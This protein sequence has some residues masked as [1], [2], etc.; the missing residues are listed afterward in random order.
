MTTT[1]F[2]ISGG[3]DCPDILVTVE[4]VDGDLRFTLSMANTGPTSKIG[5][6]LG[7]FV[8]LADGKESLI[9][10][11]GIKDGSGSSFDNAGGYTTAEDLTLSIVSGTPP[12]YD[13]LDSLDDP[14]ANVGGAGIDDLDF[15]IQFGVGGIGAGKGDYQQVTF[16]LTGLSLSDLQGADFAIRLQSVGTVD[17]DR[18]DSCKLTGDFPKLGSITGEKYLDS[19]GALAGG[20][21][22]AQSGWTINLYYDANK[23]GNFEND[24][25]VFKTVNTDASGVY[26][27]ADLMAGSYK[28]E[29]VMQGGWYNVAPLSFTFQITN[30][31]ENLGSS[32]TKGDIYDFVNTEFGSLKVTKY[33]DANGNGVIDGGETTKLA[34]WTFAVDINGDGDTDDVGERLETDASGSVTFTGLKIG[35]NYTVTEVMTDAQKAAWYQTVGIGGITT[36]VAVSGGQA[37]A[38]FANTEYGKIT[39]E[40]YRDSNGKLDGGELTKVAG[41]KVFLY[42]NGTD[43]NGDGFTD[44]K[45]GEATTN[46]DGVYSFDKLV[47][48]SYKIVEEVK[49]GWYNVGAKEFTFSVTTS[50]QVIGNNST[51]DSYDFINAQ[52]CFEGRTPGFWKQAQNYDVKAM[53][54]SSYLGL[55]KYADLLKLTY[56]QAFGIADLDKAG[57]DVTWRVNNK[58]VGFD[59]DKGTLLDALSIEG[60][61]AQG[62]FLRHS[63]AALL[64]SLADTVD[65]AMTTDD[66]LAFVR[67][68]FNSQNDALPGADDA[69]ERSYLGGIFEGLNELGESSESGFICKVVNSDFSI[70]GVFG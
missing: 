44:S 51:V 26:S 16:T 67:Q 3:D 48:G 58:T 34:G 10:G 38:D 68:A 46:A 33:L 18:E 63:A 20:T 8:D 41:W 60:G 65:Y 55:T 64:N 14:N 42:E 43:I 27:F 2:T 28:V 21:L 50:G 35:Q 53:M 62:A 12:N 56:E 59:I 61:G 30:A 37:T 19:N 40:K 24:G 29:E 66:V 11:L 15:G 45:L 7:F 47:T 13:D 4:Q 31:G 1:S 69:A 39:G 22:T 49:S 25:G 5:D 17:G 57:N 36:S 32:G 23:D 52:T 6:I 54:D 70:G 9:A